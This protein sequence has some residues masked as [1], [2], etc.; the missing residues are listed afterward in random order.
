MTQAKRHGNPITHRGT[1]RGMATDKRD[2]QRANREEKKAAEAKA[3]RRRDLWATIK[4]W[5]IYAVAI[6]VIFLVLTFL[7]N[8]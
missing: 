5:T 3:K 1:L 6:V 8:S 4:K 2:R 7:L